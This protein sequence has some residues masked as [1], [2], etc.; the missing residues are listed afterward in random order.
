MMVPSV[1]VVVVVVMTT[2]AVSDIIL[3]RLR[4][5]KR[6]QTM[7]T[8]S[9]SD[10]SLARA[11]SCSSSA[12]PVLLWTCFPR[13]SSHSQFLLFSWVLLFSQIILRICVC[14]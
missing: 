14:D 5:I 2:P 8:A 9:G 10:C 12:L 7:K 13:N 6:K 3:I 1:V 11:R 4:V